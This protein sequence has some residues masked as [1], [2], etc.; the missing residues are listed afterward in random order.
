MLL[1]G[2]LG[3]AT[4]GG[5]GVARVAA[6]CEDRVAISITLGGSVEIHD[7]GRVRRTVVRAEQREDLD[8]LLF[9]A[10]AR[11]WPQ[12]GPVEPSPQ[13]CRLRYQSA[14]GECRQA[15]R[16]VIASGPGQSLVQLLGDVVE[17]ELGAGR[18]AQLGL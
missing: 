1:L 8:R 17:A 11:E 5:S 13:A 16:E 3:C 18:R 9:A 7:R 10:G 14:A 12:C 15:T 2:G 4:T 6:G